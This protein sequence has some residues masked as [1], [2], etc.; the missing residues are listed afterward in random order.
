YWFV[1]VDISNDPYIASYTVDAI[2]HKKIFFVRLKFGFKVDHKV[3]VMF[4]KIVEDLVKSGEFDLLSNYPSLRKHKMYADFK[5][6]LLNT[7]VASDNKLTT[8]ENFVVKG[9][10]LFKSMGL[11]TQEDFGLE[12]TN[13]ETEMV[14]ISVTDDVEIKL[15]RLKK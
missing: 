1:H 9:Y 7:R 14:P 15:E 13:I 8:W 3:N 12:L 6:I 11:P 4:K 2:I 10:R 5:F